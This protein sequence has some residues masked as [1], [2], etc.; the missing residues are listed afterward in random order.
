MISSS[1][2]IIASNWAGLSII[3]CLL[4]IS[5][6]MQKFVLHS[7]VYH[8]KSIP[9]NELFMQR[10]L[11]SILI[12]TPWSFNAPVNALPVYCAPWSVLNIPGVLCL[13]RALFKAL[14]QKS[15]SRGHRDF[16]GQHIATGPIHY[17]RQ[18]DKAVSQTNVS[19]VGAPH[20]IRFC[21]RHLFQQIRIHLMPLSLTAGV[22]FGSYWQIGRASCR[23]RV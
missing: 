14:T 22:W 17:C 2:D 7:A 15:S 12:W 23:E 16:P 19:Y 21:D 4:T 13:R 11:P 20:L 8:D 6:E 5:T 18:V 9:L 10:P 1:T 3:Q